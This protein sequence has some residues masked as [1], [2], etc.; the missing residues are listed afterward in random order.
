MCAA[1]TTTIDETVLYD[2]LTAGYL[3]G[4]GD[5]YARYYTANTPT[6]KLMNQQSGAGDG[7]CWA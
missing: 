7:H 3:L 6:P 4:T 1:T 2:R 5:K